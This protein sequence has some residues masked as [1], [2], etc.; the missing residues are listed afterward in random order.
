MAEQ[1]IY[2]TRINT[3]KGEMQIDYNA[4][5]NLPK[6]PSMDEIALVKHK[7]IVSDITN[8]P[9]SLPANG[10]NADTLDSKHASDFA[11]ATDFADL[12]SKF[13]SI[14]V[15]ADEL[16]HV[17]GV[18]SNIQTQ[19]NG[20]APME[21]NHSVDAIISGTLPVNK[22]GTGASD[23]TNALKNLGAAASGHKHSAADITSGTLPMARGGT[24][25]TDAITALKMLISENKGTSLPA[26]GNT[27]RVFFKKVTLNG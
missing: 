19:L 5:A 22:G 18:T 13:E 3:D 8:F 11:N 20:K 7:H 6:I 14:T 16:N 12:K 17:D 21:H 24:G 25:A 2:I 9:T 23:A 15:T 26:A 1:K 4:L 10:G 27:G